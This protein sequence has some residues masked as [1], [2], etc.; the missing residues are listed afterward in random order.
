M[1]GGIAGVVLYDAMITAFIWQ[2][3]DLQELIATNWLPAS[4]SFRGDGHG[5]TCI[6]TR[7]R[8]HVAVHSLEGWSCNC[9]GTTE[10]EQ[11]LPSPGHVEHDP[12]E[13][14]ETQLKT[15]REV[16]QSSGVELADVKAIG[17]TNQRNNGNLGPRTG[18]PVQNA[19]VWQSRI[20]SELCQE[21]ADQGHVQTIRENGFVAGC[22]I[23]CQQNWAY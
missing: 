18:Q 20:T 2:L 11:I 8:H 16:L 6:G 9:S 4:V 17:I 14:W 13:I 22:A 3:S 10:F 12:D 19:I 5:T 21:I 7:S 23:L 15:A 1:L